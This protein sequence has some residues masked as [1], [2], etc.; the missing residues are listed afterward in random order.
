[1]AMPPSFVNMHPCFAASAADEEKQEK[2]AYSV[3][4]FFLCIFDREQRSSF[5]VLVVLGVNQVK[6]M[7]QM[8]QEVFANKMC[9]ATN[10]KCFNG[11]NKF[12]RTNF[13]LNRTKKVTIG[14]K[15]VRNE[16]CSLV[17]PRATFCGLEW[18]LMILHDLLWH[19]MVLHG[20]F[21]LY[22]LLWPCYGLVWAFYG[23][24]GRISIWK[25]LN[26]LF[27]RS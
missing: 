10:K 9:Y 13:V 24:Y 23:F 14:T 11:N 12:S 19:F 15:N 22:G 25:D 7:L 2:D 26:R 5:V 27:S 17:R 3:G 4:K 6:K 21:I 20:L 18:S 8:E 1:M 16:N